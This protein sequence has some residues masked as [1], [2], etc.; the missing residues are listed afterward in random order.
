MKNVSHQ[1]DGCS[2]PFTLGLQSLEQ[3]SP[4]E[5]GLQLGRGTHKLSRYMRLGRGRTTNKSNQYN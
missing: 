2:G 3:H 5:G 1:D 4:H